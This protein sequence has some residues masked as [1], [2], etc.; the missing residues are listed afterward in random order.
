MLIDTNITFAYKCSICGSFKVS[1]ISIFKLSTFIGRI[2]SCGCKK[3]HLLILKNTRRML[4][5]SSPCVACGV[6]HSHVVP[7]LDILKG[8]CEL[9]CPSTM[10]SG[11][12]IGNGSQVIKKV[13]KMVQSYDELLDRLGFERSCENTQAMYDSI[14]WIHDIALHGSLMCRCGSHDIELTADSDKIGLRCRRC[15]NTRVIYASSYSDIQNYLS[16]DYLLLS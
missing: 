13:D 5:V 3:A 8:N 6:N 15:L 10:I 14:N 11:C 4:V 9:K 16:K 2:S 12:F 1:H 7:L